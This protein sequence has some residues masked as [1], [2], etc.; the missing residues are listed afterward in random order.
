MAEKITLTPDS[1]LGKLIREWWL[2]LNNDNSGRAQLKR[3][4]SIDEIVMCPT[5]Q[6]FYRYLLTCNVWPINA[7]TWQNDKLAVIAGLLAHIETDDSQNFPVRASVGDKPVIS[8]L[9]FKGL[10]KT[11]TDDLFANLRRLLPLINY[12]TNVIQLACDIYYWNDKTKKQWA[13]SYCWPSK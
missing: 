9:R 4:N 12:Q 3:C 1:R 8:E 13:Y 7:A 2:G 10:L 6:R 11:D 5:Y